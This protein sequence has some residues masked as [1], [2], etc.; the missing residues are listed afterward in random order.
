MLSLVVG[1]R[2]QSRSDEETVTRASREDVADAGVLA[3]VVD[4]GENYCGRGRAR[5]VVLV[6]VVNLI[7]PLLNLDFSLIASVKRAKH[8]SLVP[9]NHFDHCVR[10]RS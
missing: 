6:R 10:V 4:N 9:T 5:G 3:F 2:L 1:S 8:A 7:C